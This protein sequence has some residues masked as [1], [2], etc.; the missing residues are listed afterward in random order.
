[1]LFDAEDRIVQ[2]NQ[3]YREMLRIE[4][5]ILERGITYEQFI[6]RG[7]EMHAFPNQ[8]TDPEAIRAFVA[9]RVAL[10]QACAGAWEASRFGGDLVMRGDQ[11]RTRAGGIVGVRVDITDYRRQQQ[12]LEAARTLLEDAIRAMP[13]AVMILDAE[14]RFITWNPQFADLVGDSS[15]YL[16][17]GSTYED[18]VREALSRGYFT[19]RGQ[20][21]ADFLAYVMRQHRT[22]NAPWLHQ[23]GERWIRLENRRTSS[24]GMVGIRLDVTE[25]KDREAEI[26]RTRVLLEDALGA[27]PCSVVLYDENDRLQYWNA[28]FSEQFEPH[29]HLLQAGKSYETLL[30]E[31][32]RHGF[33]PVEPEDWDDWMAT[34]MARRREG[35][36]QTE[37]RLANGDWLL[38]MERRTRQGGVVGVRLDISDQKAREAALD[39][40]RAEAEAANKAKSTFLANM[41]HEIRTPMNGIMGMNTLLLDSDLDAEQRHFAQAVQQSAEA[42]LV[43]IDD[44]LDV[45][46]MEAGKLSL[47]IDEADLAQT[48]EAVSALLAPRAANQNIEIGDMIDPSLRRRF[49]FDP[50]R[51]RQVLLNLAGNAVKFTHEGWVSIEARPTERPTWAGADVPADRTW[52][53]F[54]IV[55]TGIGISADVLPRLF[56]KFEQAD[57]SVTRRYGGT[58]LGLAICRELV[59]L[60]GGRIE[61]ESL[62]GKGS[63]FWFVL[64]LTASDQPMVTTTPGSLAGRRMLVVDDLE[65]N[66]TILLRALASMDVVAD[67]VDSGPAAFDRIREAREAGQPYACVLLD[68]MMPVISG[69]EVA[70]QLRADPRNAGMRI[71]FLSSAGGHGTNS[72]DVDASLTKP[73]RF[74]S[75]ADELAA[76]LDVAYPVPMPA[77][78]PPSSP[79][80]QPPAS[81]RRVLLVEDNP[82]NR[83]IAVAYLASAG[84]TCIT[85]GSGEAA[86]ELALTQPPPDL[87]LMDVQMPG[88]DGTEA[89]ARLRALGGAWVGLPIIAM[90]AHAMAGTREKMLAS[91]MT[92]YISKPVARDQLLQL[93]DQH[94]PAEPALDTGTLDTLRETLGPAPFSALVQTFRADLERRAGHIEAAA[95]NLAW[96][97]L[98]HT[99]HDLA[100]SAGAMGATELAAAARRLM[101]I[102]QR[103][104]SAAATTVVSDLL[105]LIRSTDDMVARMLATAG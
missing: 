68:V 62:V 60:M 69:P 15:D 71:V 92:D 41:S 18:M 49:R 30:L 7:I 95:A 52:V 97:D 75:L 47:T 86:L 5:D 81:G 56:T 98:E 26:E 23:I 21:E 54:D 20:S 32:L 8:P 55:D 34:V 63:R 74:Q 64:P 4:D 102:A 104:D 31:T 88:M 79:A 27:M 22:T 37:Y 33:H 50:V 35:T 77:A 1:V 24:G 84:H 94:L 43:V 45:S 39:H 36:G 73:I 101:A 44:I 51:L 100:G 11:R 85:A 42:L 10:H 66:R 17:V 78:P 87:V 76:V 70:A 99:A 65:L 14:D 25:L 91:G 6:W 28:K 9:E 13:A 80:P 72:A 53:R 93:L 67:A 57:S 46:K 38:A 29:A 59:A 96:S 3:R 2:W 89:T 61:A 90:T 16:R 19:L 40:A 103:Q 82:I 58:G 48:I 105:R 12:E 83:Q